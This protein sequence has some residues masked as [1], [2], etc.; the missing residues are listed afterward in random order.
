M[1]VWL[2][3]FACALYIGALYAIA[4][5]GD[6]QAAATRRPVSPL[7]YSLALTVYCTSWTFF[8]AVGTATEG[9][10]NF[11]PIYLGPALIFLLAPSLIRRIGDITQ[12]E[13]IGSLSDFLAARY[14][15]SRALAAAVTL[16]AVAGTVPYIALQL[17]SLATSFDALTL[18]TS[19]VDGTGTRN[20]VLLTAVALGLFAILFG[21]RHADTTRR[22]VGLMQVLAFEA[23]VKLVALAAVAILSLSVLGDLEPARASETAGQFR[24]GGPASDFVTMLILAMAAAICLP[25]QFHVTMVERGRSSDV[26]TARWVFPLY[27]ALTSVVVVPIAIAGSGLLGP[28]YLPDLYVLGLPL[29]LGQDGVALLVFLGGLSAAAGMVVVSCIALSTMVTSDLVVPFLFRRGWRTQAGYTDGR[30]LVTARRI[31]IMVV[32]ALAYAYYQLALTTIALAEIGLISFAAAIQFA[33][34]LLGAVY[35]RKG[36]LNGALGGLVAGILAWLYTLVLPQI[37]GIEAMRAAG[38][39]GLVDPQALFAV[40]LGGPLT[41]G[42][43]WS[44]G[45]N[46]ALYVIGSLRATV[47]LRDRIQAGVFTNVQSDESDAL[48]RYPARASGVTPNGLKTLA[49]R[50]LGEDAVE[51]A[52]VQF[53]RDSGR[54]I[55]GDEPADWRLVQRTERLLASVLG[56]SS[57]R[58]VMSSALAGSAVALNDVLSILDQQTQAQRFDRHMLQSMLEN[59]SQGISVVDGEQRLVAWNSAYVEMFHYPPSLIRLGQPIQDLIAH[60]IERGWIETD[61][62]EDEVLNRVAHMRR[63]VRHHFE[64]RNP[65]GRWLR[66][67]GMPMPGGGYVS[68]FTDITQDK[69]REAALIEAAETLEARVAERTDDLHA[70]ARDLE[71]ARRSAESANLSKTRFLAA[72]SHDLLQPLNAARLFLGALEEQQADEGGRKLARRADRAIESADQLLRG[73][74]DI[75]RL[76]QG[77]IEPKRVEIAAHDLI[78][79]LAEEA[80]P[81]AGAVGL[82]IRH[83][84][85]SLLVETDADFLRS[86][87]RNFL[88]NARRYTRSGRILLG[89][90]RRGRRVRFEVWDTGPGIAEARQ[91][92][93]FE[94]FRRFEEADNTGVRGAGLGLAIARRLAEAM[95]AEIGVRSVPGKGSVFFVEVDRSIGTHSIAADLSGLPAASGRARFPGLRVLCVDDETAIL[96][97]MRLLLEA[98]ECDVR[99]ARTLGEALDAQAGFDPHLVFLDLQLGQGESGLAVADALNRQAGGQLTAALITARSGQ[100]TRAA[101]RA[102]CLLDVLAKPLEPDRLRGALARMAPL[103]GYEPPGEADAGAAAAAPQAAE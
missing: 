14:G 56:S 47:R 10:W 43:I 37:I 24:L 96:D 6:R 85:N 26:G 39:A 44:L 25:R 71:C 51:A 79:E 22:N 72:A 81:M 66:I 27:L 42:L 64:R 34:A 16:A 53:A 76:D 50:F 55:L 35:W 99:T 69:A 86:I 63:G 8:G 5:R 101:A 13:S 11:L 2:V 18:G 29:A 62:P 49:A 46:T 98:W 90:R 100:E 57:A 33:P 4:W 58:V 74:L 30:S 68:T 31:V 32:L 87:L 82:T 95:E 89:A 7:V 1:P 83:V 48:P 97:S 45:L 54:P 23:V 65:D 40:D 94:E 38:F 102:H 3:I 73:L 15:K 67:S 28:G 12:R 88:S 91:R 61:D 59:I 93:I 20:T 19:G 21:A 77:E 17:K 80:R 9:G 36:H 41:H 84:P 60:N 103:G 75:S 92:A 78:E 52:F 70:M